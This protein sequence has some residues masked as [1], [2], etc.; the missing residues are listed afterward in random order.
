VAPSSAKTPAKAQGTHDGM[1]RRVAA[2]KLEATTRKEL[3]NLAI[4]SGI[5]S[6]FLEIYREACLRKSGFGMLQIGVIGSFVLTCCGMGFSQV[7]LLS[8]GVA[9]K[10]FDPVDLARAAYVTN[11]EEDRSRLNILDGSPAEQ[12]QSN[13]G[14]DNSGQHH[15]FVVRNLRRGLQDQKELYAAPFKVK[16]LKWDALF[17]GTTGV[18]LATDR[19]VMRDISND[20]VDIGHSVALAT[21]L[22]TAAI[23]GVTWLYGLKTGDRHADETG[24]LTLE[25]LANTFL[26][27]TPMQFI[28]GR[29]RPDEGTGNGRFWRHGGFNTSFPAG[30]PMFTWA[31]ASVVAHEY[32]KTWVKVLVYGVAVT[33]SGGRLVGRNHFPSDV[34]VGSILGYLI[35]THIFH[36]HCDPQF[37]DACTGS[38]IR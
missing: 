20:N 21:L 30:H 9:N 24:Y 16:N 35:G 34:W 8:A 36:A 23:P 27:Y 19:Q 38:T 37:S 14:Q 1:L 3:K 4:L 25:S 22:G 11:V 26:I 28:A 17:L 29:E 31:M 15:G 7:G 12:Q 32:P 6:H 33:V 10:T 2:F 18:L 13:L 5:A